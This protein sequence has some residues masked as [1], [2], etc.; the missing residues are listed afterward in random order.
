[1]AQA[2]DL[3]AGFR[4]YEMVLQTYGKEIFALLVPFVAWVL[5]TLFRS[6]AKLIIAR[7]HAFTF[8]VVTLLLQFL[9]LKTPYGH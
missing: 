7:P 6:R 3:C 4:G 2:L 1:M 9:V 5:N 8:Y